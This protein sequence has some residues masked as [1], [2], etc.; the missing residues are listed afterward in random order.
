MAAAT[1]LGVPKGPLCGRLIKGET[2]ELPN[3]NKVRKARRERE[4]RGRGE[5]GEREGRGRRAGRGR[6]SYIVYRSSQKT[7]W[8]RLLLDQYV[9]P[10]SPPLLTFLPLSPH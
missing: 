5:G 6:C 9:F 4:G 7:A 1:K 3:G 8:D 10:I 2:I